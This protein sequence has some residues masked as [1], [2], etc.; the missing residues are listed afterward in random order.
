M[1][2][3][4][5]MNLGAKITTHVTYTKGCSDWPPLSHDWGGGRGTIS[6]YRPGARQKDRWTKDRAWSKGTLDGYILVGAFESGFFSIRDP[7]FYGFMGVSASEFCWLKENP[8]KKPL[9]SFLLAILT[10]VEPLPVMSYHILIVLLWID[11]SKSRCFLSVPTC[12]STV[13]GNM[14]NN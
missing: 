12:Q 2:S 13:N 4:L 8:R 1:E 11:D 14:T 6:L 9:S 5:S 7:S 3:L 10:R